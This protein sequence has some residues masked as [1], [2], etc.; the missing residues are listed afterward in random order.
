MHDRIG[1]L[2]YS[3]PHLRDDIAHAEHVSSDSAVCTAA[4]VDDFYIM[5]GE[6]AAGV[7]LATDSFCARLGFH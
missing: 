5:E 2:E 7:R 1:A 3:P 6:M 4:S